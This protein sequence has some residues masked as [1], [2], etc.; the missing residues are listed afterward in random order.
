MF[1]GD[2]TAVKYPKL[3]LLQYYS[4]L[5]FVKLKYFFKSGIKIP[6]SP[7][8]FN[9]IFETKKCLNRRNHFP[10]K[11]L[12]IILCCL[13]HLYS[14]SYSLI[15]MSLFSSLFLF[16]IKLNALLSYIFSFSF[17]DTHTPIILDVKICV[18]QL[19]ITNSV[20]VSGVRG[21]LAKIPDERY[22]FLTLLRCHK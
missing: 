13:F 17:T 16:S 14:V 20:R 6:Y 8:A 5:Y 15:L 12:L 2:S 21:M 4:H 22:L 18:Q 1:T 7:F 3:K 10:R 9:Y 19:N 11:Q